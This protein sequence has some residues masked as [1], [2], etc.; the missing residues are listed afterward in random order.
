M[1]NFI[2][3]LLLFPFRL[4]W[5]LIKLIFWYLTIRWILSLFG[6]HFDD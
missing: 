4:L 6:I 3:K 5:W 2:I 1:G